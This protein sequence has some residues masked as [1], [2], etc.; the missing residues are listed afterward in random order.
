MCGKAGIWWSAFI[1]TLYDTGLR[2][3]A[4]MLR[5]TTDL[6]MQSG[7]LAIDAADQKQRKAQSLKLHSD[8]LSFVRAMT[9]A[10][11]P[12]LFPWPYVCS[13]V[14]RDNYRAI[15][16]AAALPSSK[17][18]LFH[19]LRRTSATFGNGGYEQLSMVKRFKRSICKHYQ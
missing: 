9:P 16:Q 13:K 3:N 10:D 12:F 5:P 19:K 6:D 15:L 7:W 14:I 11:R 4:L 1:L 18:D 17:R 2:F 8:T